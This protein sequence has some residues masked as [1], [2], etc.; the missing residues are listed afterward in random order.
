M[1][2]THTSSA[3]EFQAC[4]RR[5]G[6]PMPASRSMST[7][8]PSRPAAVAVPYFDAATNLTIDTAIICCCR[9]IVM[10]SPMRGRS[11][12]KPGWSGRSMPSFVV[13]LTTGQRWQ[14]DLGDGRCRCGYSMSPAVC[15]TRA[16]ADYLALAPLIWQQRA[17]RSRY[18]P[19][20]GTLYQRLVQPL[21]LAALNV[22]PPEGSAGLAGAVVRETLLAGAGLPAADRTG[23]PERGAGRTRDHAA[24]GEGRRGSV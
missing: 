15:P 12:P 4:R 1:P 10:H 7:R 6:W 13:D 22:D 19:V 2:K 5:S 14:L 24:A 21:L 23:R 20:P 9:A 17:S 16:C 3:P 8:P 11:A 18:H